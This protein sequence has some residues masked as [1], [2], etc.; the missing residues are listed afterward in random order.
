MEASHKHKEAEAGF[1]KLKTIKNWANTFGD[2]Y[3][4]IA[5]R[6][7]YTLEFEA[8]LFYWHSL[9]QSDDDDD[10]RMVGR[11]N[12][13]LVYSQMSC[14]RNA[15]SMIDNV[16]KIPDSIYSHF[17]HW[18]NL[19]KAFAFAGTGQFLKSLALLDGLLRKYHLLCTDI[20]TILSIDTLKK[21]IERKV[22]NNQT[23]NY[24]KWVH[25]CIRRTHIHPKCQHFLPEHLQN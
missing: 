15:L 5:F 1:N 3:H 9:S 11:V 25:E 2:I 24:E 22:E 10:W 21:T 20:D 17:Q 13:S 19:A 8:A 18:I 6:L 16:T 12:A 23:E 4:A 14:F 7:Y